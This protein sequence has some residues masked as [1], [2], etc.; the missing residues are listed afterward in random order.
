MNLSTLKRRV[1]SVNGMSRRIVAFYKSSVTSAQYETGLTWYSDAYDFAARIGTEY[2]LSVE[3]VAGVVSALSPA[4][5]WVVNKED[6]RRLIDNWSNIG[7]PERVKVSTYGQNKDKAIG[8]L[9]SKGSY[10]AVVDFFT[11]DT[12]TLNFFCNIANPERTNV[13]TVDRHAIG[14]ALGSTDTSHQQ[15]CITKKRYRDIKEAYTMAAE[16]LGHRV[17]C[18][19]QAICWIS[20]REQYV[21]NRYTLES[22]Y[23]D[24]PF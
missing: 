13:V 2:A 24:A 1:L 23:S 19:L 14:I 17:P 8:I 3:T 22:E 15:L 11:A 10:N 6:A 5:S 12:K 20:Y 18:N 16:Q 21:N 7:N 9:E 4:V